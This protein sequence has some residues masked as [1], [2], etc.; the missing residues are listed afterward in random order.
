MKSF[1]KPC[2]TL[3]TAS[4]IPRHLER[5]EVVT[6]FHLTTGHVLLGVYLHW[7]DV[8]ANEPGRSV[9]IPEWMATTCSNALDSMNMRLMRHRQS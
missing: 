9:A 3:A 4:P 8:G 1:R 7:L 2:E 6:R 5:A